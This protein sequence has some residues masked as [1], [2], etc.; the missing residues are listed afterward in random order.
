ML[1][2][3]NPTQRIQ[4]IRPVSANNLSAPSSS[5]QA[6][7]CHVEYHLDASGEAIVLWDDIVLAFKH[8]LYVQHAFNK[9][10]FLKD[11]DE[12]LDPP[13]I[14]AFPDDVLEVVVK[15]QLKQPASAST[16]PQP[17]VQ[18][19][20][21]PHGDAALAMAAV[22]DFSRAPQ[23]D[24]DHR[25]DA[26][27]TEWDNFLRAPHALIE[28]DGHLVLQD[29]LGKIN[30][31]GEHV[32]EDMQA[33]I[34]R[35]LKTTGPGAATD[36]PDTDVS[37]DEQGR[38]KF[39]GYS[40]ATEWFLKAAEGGYAAAQFKMGTKYESGDDVLQDYEKA[41]E[42]YRK[43]AEQDNVEA[44]KW[45]AKAADKDHADAQYCMG[46]FYDKAYGVQQNFSD[47]KSWYEKATSQ[48]HAPS[49]F[50]LAMLYYQ[51]KG[52]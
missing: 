29:S 4:A 13:R 27:E 42:W 40:R 19:T 30:T 38:H 24:P 15:S 35:L 48:G 52:V 14:A 39:L 36:G 12:E 18:T 28:Q 26:E 51:G 43:A 16:A 10:D 7:V 23:Y 3:D 20:K 9:L 50:N 44:Q 41:A 37:H 34:E 5:L 47:A 8:A 21:H 22:P 45:Y 46:V 6:N 11:A 25:D 49:Q 31:K 2:T 1:Q 17:P 33:N 32:A